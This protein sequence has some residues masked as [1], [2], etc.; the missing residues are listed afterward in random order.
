MP[1]SRK[2]TN[3]L[4]RK[5]LKAKWHARTKLTSKSHPF[6]AEVFFQGIQQRKIKIKTKQYIALQI[7]PDAYNKYKRKKKSL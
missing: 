6:S 3:H 2:E 5:D 1:Q 7:Y 4:F